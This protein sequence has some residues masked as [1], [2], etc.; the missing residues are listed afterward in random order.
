ALWL[1]YYNELSDV[2]REGGAGFS[3]WSGVYSAEPCYIVQSDFSYMISDDMFV[4]FELAHLQE[5]C[6]KIKNTIFHLDGPGE[7][8]HLDAILGIGELDCVQWIPGEGN[9]PSAQWQEVNRKIKAAGKSLY[10]TGDPA[11]FDAVMADLGD[12]TRAYYAIRE[13]DDAFG[14]LQNK[15]VLTRFI[16]KW[17]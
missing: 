1:R 2:I 14:G 7:L 9:P 16:D 17:K 3:D 4:D 12:G 5:S 11:N 15:D 6:E 8:S 10:I 13:Y